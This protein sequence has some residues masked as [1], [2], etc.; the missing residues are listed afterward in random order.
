MLLHY[1]GANG[2]EGFRQRTPKNA[3]RV[4]EVLLGAGADIDAVAGMYGGYQTLGLVATSIHPVTA[5]V[6][7]ELM[8]YLL[9]R[10]AS[11]GD[12]SRAAWAGLINACHANGRPAAAE[13]LAR[14]RADALDLE[15]A[16]GVGRLD[17][18]QSFF[19]PDGRLK[20]TATP[21]QMKD[22]LAWACE[23]GRT[24]VVEF[25]LD[26]GLDAGTPL[27]RPH[28][29]TG[30]HWAAFN[31]HVDA[32][33]ALLKRHAPVDARDRTFDATPLGW[34]LHAWQTTPMDGARKERYYR[35]VDLLVGAGA[36]VEPAWLTDELRADA[37]M[38]AALRLT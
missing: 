22:G 20:A 37:R 24:A 25:L 36:T 18:V 7:E 10:G 29:Q 13:F 3:V 1:V 28:G 6:Q 11:V 26:R 5:G 14:R 21:A 38:R 33:E 16:A 34:A 9:G 15:A 17:L 8:A 23:Y 35:T 30:L 27:P 4:A 32:V 12:G 31:A 19:E 2:V